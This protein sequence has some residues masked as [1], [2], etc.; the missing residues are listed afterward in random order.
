MP[1]TKAEDDDDAR[2]CIV[3]S[4]SL[5]VAQVAPETEAALVAAVQGAAGVAEAEVWLTAPCLVPLLSGELAEYCV[6]AHAA[7]AQDVQRFDEVGFCVMPRALD[8]AALAEIHAAAARRIAEAEAALRDGHP[9]IEVGTTLFAFEE[10]SSRGRQ[11]FDL[12]FE[13]DHGSAAVFAAA[14]WGAWTPLVRAAL[15]RD[16]KCQVSVVYSRPGADAQDWH[17]DGKH[18]GAAAVSGRLGSTWAGEQSGV[19][20]TLTSRRPRGTAPTPT[21]QSRAAR[22]RPSWA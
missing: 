14:R 8:A 10:M 5:A 13:D 11:R 17:S 9:D 19:R 3:L 21:H 20:E 15:G 18:L 4:C 6:S 1:E 16:L 12:L 22:A 7:A 2:F